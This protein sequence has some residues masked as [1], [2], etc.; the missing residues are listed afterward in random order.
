MSLPRS[1][2]ATFNCEWHRP[3]SR[4]GQLL[5][6]A[7]MAVD[8]DIWCLTEAFENSLADNGH[9]ICAAYPYPDPTQRIVILW[10]KSPW[11]PVD[12]LARL[13]A[14]GFV[15]GETD[16][17]VGPL[18][19]GGV[20]IPYRFSGRC[21]EPPKKVWQDHC[22][23]IEALRDWIGMTPHR[24][25][26]LGDFNQRIPRKYQPRAL[27]DALSQGVLAQLPAATAGLTGPDGDLAIDH[28]CHSPDLW[29]DKARSLSNLDTEGRA[30]SDHFGVACEVIE[31][32]P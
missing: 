11:R 15:C 25:I 14:L 3:S 16:T 27:F 12:S 13:D 21:D 9:I 5:R 10:S 6:R 31:K 7:M 29:A 30:F 2:L 8:A 18:R 4:K 28:I 32:A 17:P 26:V 22:E 1:T 24:T 20:C 19:V 23:Y